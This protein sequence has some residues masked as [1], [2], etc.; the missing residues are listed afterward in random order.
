MTI[1]HLFDRFKSEHNLR[2]RSN[3]KTNRNKI[4]WFSV[5]IKAKRCHF[6][7]YFPF[8]LS[9]WTGL[10]VILP[11][12][13]RITHAHTLLY[14][15]MDFFF[16][17]CAV[18]LLI[19]PRKKRRR[20][21]TFKIALLP[22]VR[23]LCMYVCC[24]C[25]WISEWML[26][27]HCSYPH[28]KHTYGHIQ[29]PVDLTFVDSMVLRG[30]SW[31]FITFVVLSF[32]FSFC[33]TLDTFISFLVRFRYSFYLLDFFCCFIFGGSYL[34]INTLHWSKHDTILGFN[35][36][37]FSFCYYYF[38]SFTFLSLSL[39]CTSCNIIK[40]YDL[41]RR[42]LCFYTAAT[43]AAAAIASYLLFD[44]LAYVHH[45]YQ[46]NNQHLRP[47]IFLYSIF[48]NNILCWLHIDAIV[49]VL[50]Y[51]LGSCLWEKEQQQQN[52][53]KKWTT[54]WEHER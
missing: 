1:D 16:V 22:P 6:F 37:L 29:S 33:S 43:T 14:T 52:S 54:K 9:N 15:Y 19:V 24:A 46:S 25:K 10:I 51:S 30:V 38:H 42:L 3:N 26:T 35:L 20:K 34:K 44:M 8:G 31:C 53:K 2:N 28:T 32:F 7:V 40:S 12:Y 18:V 39:L 17:V 36:Y 5:P 49:M 13:I 50:W 11:Q 45:Q 23:T 21:K 47:D 48:N 41:I 27:T 4:E